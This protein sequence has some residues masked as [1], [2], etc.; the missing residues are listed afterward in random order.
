M[1]TIYAMDISQMNDWNKICKAYADKIGA[2]LLFVNETSFGIQTSSGELLHIY[3]DELV[4][5]L[6][7]EIWKD[8]SK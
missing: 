5:I 6:K 8:I 1:R 4:E 2:E 3:I 7:E